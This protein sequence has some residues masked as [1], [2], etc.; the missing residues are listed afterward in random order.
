MTAEPQIVNVLGEQVALNKTM[1]SP[2]E[3]FLVSF[4]EKYKFPE[5]TA[6][7]ETTMKKLFV[8]LFSASSPFLPGQKQPQP[9]CSKEEKALLEKTLAYRFGTLRDELIQERKTQSNSLRLRQS[10]GHAEKLKEYIDFLSTTEE[11]QELDEDILGESI[12]DLTDDQILELLRQFVFFVLQGRHPLKDFA[13]R[14]PNP[15]GFVTRLSRKPIQNFD[16][17]LKEYRDNKYSIPVPIEKVLQVT[18]LELESMKEEVEDTMNEKVKQILQIVSDILPEEDDFWKGLDKTNLEAVVQRLLDTIQSL[19]LELD[20]CNKKSQEFYGA[21]I[22][23]SNEKDQLEEEKQDLLAKIAILEAENTSSNS[24]SN[25]SSSGS[26]E[27]QYEA[28]FAD[29]HGQIDALNARVAALKAREAE[30]LGQL[31]EA[32]DDAEEKQTQLDMFEAQEGEL[33]NL[34]AANAKLQEELTVATAKIKGCEEL[35]ATVARLEAQLQASETRLTALRADAGELTAAIDKHRQEKEQLENKLQALQGDVDTAKGFEGTLRGLLDSLMN[36]LQGEKRVVI[37]LLSNV[38]SQRADMNLEDD[39]VLEQIVALK[40][41]LQTSETVP[42]NMA[43]MVGQILRQVQEEVAAYELQVKDLE[44][45]IA[46]KDEEIEDAKQAMADSNEILQQLRA[47]RT[48]LAEK[49]IAYETD[50]AYLEDAARAIEA[51]R[52]LKADKAELEEAKVQLTAANAALQGT[53]EALQASMNSQ[54]EA[55]RAELK[56]AKDNLAAEKAETA[57][58]E[59]AA[60]ASDAK[61]TALQKEV[62]ALEFDLQEQSDALDQEKAASA[63]R[64]AE[65]EDKKIRECEERL[66][67][68]RKEEEQK[69]VALLNA[70]GADKGTLEAR[71]AELLT[72]ITSI[73]GERDGFKAAADLEKSKAAAIVE[74][75]EA[76]RSSTQKTIAG[77]QSEAEEDQNR[78]SAAIGQATEIKDMLDTAMNT[79]DELQGQ[80]IADSA[81]RA[82]LFTL[83]STIAAWITSGAKLPRPTIDEGLNT[84]YGLNRILDAFLAGI[85]VAAPESPKAEVRGDVYT[86]GIARCYILFYMTYIYARHFPSKRDDNSNTQ[87]E[88]TTFLRGILTDFYKQLDAGI[89]GK[90]D[91]LGAG[92]IPVQLKAKYVM[93]LLLPLLKTMEMIHEAGKR[94]A[95]FLKFSVLD[96]D[97]LATLHKLHRVAQD[98]IK[99]AGKDIL[100]RINLYVLR[101]T[102]NV[103]DD[104]SNLYLRFITESA[105][106]KEFPVVMYIS[107]DAREIPKFTFATDID[108]EKYLS[109]PVEKGASS[110]KVAAPLDKQLTAT[111]I[112][113][114]NLLFYLFLFIVKD[115]LSSV[116]GELS[117]SGCPLPRILRSP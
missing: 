75:L 106:Q 28:L 105:S 80:V 93:N 26:S 48:G 110:P 12:G 65:L 21:L 111:P 38:Q 71:I 70:Q 104:I 63:Q 88:V 4:D 6:A 8:Q 9:P 49:G 43:S 90:L 52:Q 101:R 42:T 92:G 61:V 14:D 76:L 50:K 85:P 44:G 116:E 53:M 17:F 59:G 51:E 24:S 81:E 36:L 35:Q 74:E 29:L 100:K 69:R 109:S 113:S 86:T 30:L 25:S 41:E 37:D 83:V 20:E 91:P 46:A 112:F 18:Q 27:A 47:G 95:D 64:L 68:L 19:R 72:Q 96:A 56:L 99:L 89:P 66:T 32:Q 33:D 55:L 22:D 1:F 107:P 62:S 73:E 3:K 97:Q 58:L 2:A 7:E 16:A 39:K 5:M 23:V 40:T 102:G 117:K 57:R 115:Y 10:L 60:A 87:S 114:F 45:Q 31:Q 15:K 84:K 103:D 67:A 13:G 77:L 11:C 79:V 78:L 108:L 98:K 54:L 34:R 94:G 82:K